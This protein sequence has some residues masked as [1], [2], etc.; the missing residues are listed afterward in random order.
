MAAY[1]S[2][3]EPDRRFV[4]SGPAR[5]RDL[6]DLM[7]RPF[8]A[9]GKI[10]RQAP[11]HYRA[12]YTEVH[13]IPDGATGMAT[14]WDADVLIWLAGQIVDALNH[15]LWVSRHVRFTPWRLFADLGWA[16]GA[17]QYRRFHGALA[18][19]AATTVTTT[20]RNGPNWQEKPF[21]WVSDVRVSSDDG[22]ALTL[23]EWFLDTI[24]EPTRVLT[25]DPAYFRLRGG[26]ERWLYRIA[27]K[28]VGRQRGQWLFDT[29]FLYSKS[30]SLMQRGD[31]ALALRKIAGNPAFPRYRFAVV[32]SR[33][34]EYLRIETTAQSTGPVDKPVRCPVAINVDNTVGLRD[35]IPLDRSENPHITSCRVTEFNGRN[36]VHNLK[37]L[38]RCRESRFFAHRASDRTGKRKKAQEAVADR[39]AGIP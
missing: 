29:A 27:R 15:G 16:D 31:F 25:V 13:V 18:R 30:G 12:G 8:F 7:E 1:E 14:I 17:H 11:I 20:I 2:W 35:G 9:L 34:V 39:G 28:H 19:L 4:V 37:S 10:P 21:T 24:A 5:P 23:P 33:G 32:V 36:L 26:V 38:N 6:R 3:R 22:V